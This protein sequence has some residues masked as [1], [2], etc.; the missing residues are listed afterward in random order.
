[1]TYFLL[2]IPLLAKKFKGRFNGGGE[3]EF[4]MKRNLN[5]PLLDQEPYEIPL[6]VEITTDLGYN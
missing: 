2:L 4:M 1:M 6:L 5:C 3:F